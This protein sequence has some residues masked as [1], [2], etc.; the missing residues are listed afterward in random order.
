LKVSFDDISYTKIT[1]SVPWK[2][3]FANCLYFSCPAV[4]HILIR[5]FFESISIYFFIKLLVIDG[6]SLGLNLPPPAIFI[7]LVFPTPD[8]PSK[9]ALPI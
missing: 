6:T 8:S 3:N 7:K 2:N 1:I 9:I 4:S 5:Y